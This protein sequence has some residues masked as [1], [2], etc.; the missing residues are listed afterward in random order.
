MTPIRTFALT[1]LF[2][3]SLASAGLARDAGERVPASSTTASPVVT[4][5][6]GGRNAGPRSGTPETRGPDALLMAGA[7]L[8]TGR[9]DCVRF[10][11][12]SVVE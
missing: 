11:C 2:A 7:S 8:P 10:Y 4:V 1:A 6:S 5:A 9:N 12:G 3:A